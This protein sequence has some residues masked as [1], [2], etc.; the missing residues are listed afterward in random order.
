MCR[1]IAKV[2][3]PLDAT[4]LL[5]ANG[6]VWRSYWPTVEAE[7][8]LGRLDGVSVV[9]EAWQRTLESC[10]CMD[11]DV[12]RFAASTH[13]RLARQAYRLYSDV[14]VAL[15]AARDAGIPLV[16]L[17]N[18]A[19]DTQREKLQAL[20]LKRW[21]DAVIISGEV[22]VAKPDVAIFQAAKKTLGMD[23][24]NIWHVGDNLSTDIAGA[25][26]AGV[27]SVW[28][29]RRGIIPD[30]CAPKPHFEIQSL[31]ELFT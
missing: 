21:F 28:L 23:A 26:A 22:G 19:S 9:S 12:F 2:H 14:T 1:E 15:Q 10:G 4:Q 30:H 6:R 11:R 16:L 5:E 24:G 29:N 8:N 27:I 17:T 13:T 31:S 7:W 18:G 25:R 3:P 20:D